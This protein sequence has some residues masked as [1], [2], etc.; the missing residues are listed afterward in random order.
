MVHDC[1][2]KLNFREILFTM[3]KHIFETN[4]ITFLG[5]LNKILCVMP[6]IV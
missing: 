3:L 1:M 4:K 6:E 2:V 5:E